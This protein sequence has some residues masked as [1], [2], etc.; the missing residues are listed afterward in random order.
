MYLSCMP[1]CSSYLF[2]YSCPIDIHVSFVQFFGDFVGNAQTRWFF[3]FAAVVGTDTHN[4]MSVV[5][6][7][8]RQ[9]PSIALR[10]KMPVRTC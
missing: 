8:H 1:W 2:R 7:S 3:L 5:A 9:Q 6:K 10:D 4:R